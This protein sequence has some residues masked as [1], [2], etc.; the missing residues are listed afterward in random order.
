M[1]C[2]EWTLTMGFLLGVENWEIL[3]ELVNSL[4]RHSLQVIDMIRKGKG[5]DGLAFEVG[6]GQTFSEREMNR[7][8]GIGHGSGM[9]GDGF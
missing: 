2:W 3:K 7:C 8:F 6:H 5:M 1:F 9:H 4:F